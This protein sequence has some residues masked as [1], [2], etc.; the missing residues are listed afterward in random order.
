[1]SPPGLEEAFAANRPALWALAYRMLGTTADADEAVQDAFLRALERPPADLGRP[2]APW[3]VRVLMNLSRDR[4]RRRRRRPYHGA[5][6]PSPVAT[7]P[8]DHLDVT[9]LFSEGAERSTGAPPAPPD[10]RYDLLESVSMAFLVALE[11]LTPQQRAVLVLRDVCDCSGAEAAEVLGISLANVKVTLHRARRKLAAYRATRQPLTPDLQAR[12]LALMQAFG[13]AVMTGD[14][15]AALALVED[16]AIARSDGG[17]VVAAANHPVVGPA[18]IAK[19]YLGLSK[20]SEGRLQ[21]GFGHYNG[22]PALLGYDPAPPKGWGSRYVLSM[23]PGPD[24]RLRALY[25]V[26]HP[27]KIAAVDFSSVL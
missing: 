23:L 25:S 8:A 10:A 1:M 7:D 20:R 14:L 27:D 2:W 15:D 22:L 11:E 19:L 21:I 16:D 3:L 17:G 5:W 9:C 18:A 26:L 4:L 12:S 24:G 6:L 13:M